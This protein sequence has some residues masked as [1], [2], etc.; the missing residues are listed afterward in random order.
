MFQFLTVIIFCQDQRYY[1]PPEIKNA[2]EKGTRS[3]DGKPGEKYFQNRANYKIDVEF[4]PENQKVKGHARIEYF[5]NSPV[6]LNHIVLRLYQDIF[7]RGGVR[8]RKV[9][10]ADLQE[11]MQINTIE[12]NGQR[13]SPESYIFKSHTNIVYPMN[14]DPGKKTG[15]FIEWEF[16]M[17]SKTGNR[18]GCYKSGSCFIAYWYPQVAVFDDINGWDI[19]DYNGVAEF[20]TSYG[21]YTVNIQVPQSY[22]VWATGELQNPEKVLND[23]F[24]KRYNYA[25]STD[26]LV[27]VIEKKDLKRKTDITNKKTNIWRYIAKDVNDFAFA[28]SNN[29]VW[30]ATTITIKENNSYKKVLVEAAYDPSSNNFHN[31]AELAAW[32]IQDYSSDFPGVPYPYP[33]LTVFQGK[34]GME[35]PM[36]LNNGDSDY[37]GTVFVTTHEI[38]HT[39]FPFLVGINQKRYGWMDEGL[40][41]LMGQEQHLK[42]EQTY[43]FRTYYL[44]LYSEI[45]GSQ[46]DVPPIVNSGY[47]PD[48]IF[49]I[50]E[51]MRPSLA[52]WTLRDILGQDV[53]KKCVSGF[54]DIWKGKS[55]TPWDMFFTFENISGIKLDWFFK[56]WFCEFAYPDLKITDIITKDNGNEIILKN[57]GGMPFPSSLKIKY[58][59]E[60]EILVPLPANIWMHSAEYTYKC[61]NSGIVKSAEIITEGYPDIDIENNYMLNKPPGLLKK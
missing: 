53:F 33:K 16:I 9:D 38:C 43:N 7:V 42:K 58:H 39:Y 18:F 1:I 37:K 44:K 36:I 48:D 46:E 12:I 26:E 21:D 56:P 50:H 32:S 13:L 10:P 27:H 29:Y 17:P 31:V 3:Q 34:D 47:L 40:V 41:T 24:L 5:N 28:L 4:F 2:Y 25:K 45:A 19:S 49:Q 52:F 22:I 14:L 20:Y 30:D 11:G 54:I 60:T 59:N 6:N 8:G 61:N 55:P 15:I 35:F 51:Y 23:E 57:A